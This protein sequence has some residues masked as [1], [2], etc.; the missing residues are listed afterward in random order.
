MEHLLDFYNSPYDPFEPKICIDERPCQ[1]IDNVLVPIPMKPGKPLREGYEYQRNGTCTL[2]IAFDPEN[3]WRFVEVRT[4]R[5]KKDYTLFMQKV[6]EFYPFASKIHIVQDNLNTHSCDSFYQV[7]EPQQAFELANRFE[8]HFTPKKASWLNMAEIELSV[9]SRQCLN[10]R[11][12]DQDTLAR[13]SIAWANERNR[14]KASVQW[15]FTVDLARKKF[16]SK[17][18]VIEG[19]LND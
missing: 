12:A 6:A 13:E 4:R 5:T 15:S 14:K 7:L 17:Y 2:F 10:R 16:E 1:L 18:P 3:C 19:L 8:F 11:I 9:L